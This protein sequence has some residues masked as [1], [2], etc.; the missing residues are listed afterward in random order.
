MNIEI[1]DIVIYEDKLH[2]IVGKQWCDYKD[3]YKLLPYVRDLIETAYEDD[4]FKV[5]GYIKRE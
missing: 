2:I 1:G 3:K 5:E 4:V